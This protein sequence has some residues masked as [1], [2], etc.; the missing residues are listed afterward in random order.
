MMQILV[1]EKNLNG[2]RIL[3]R[4]LKMEGHAVSVAESGDQALDMLKETQPDIVLLNVFQC[5]YASDV[6]Q[7][8]KIS[9]RHQGE[10]AAALLLV[11]CSRGGG[12]LAEFM[13]PDNRYCDEAFEL[14]SAQLKNAVMYKIQQLC[15]ALRLCSHTFSPETGFN[16]QLFS[17]LMNWNPT[18]G[19]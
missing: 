7:A 18:L 2:R 14:L 5:M 9:V 1:A 15:A 6:A 19:A 8:D 16:W 13:T 4:I 11:T 3:N 10:G 12:N 17:N